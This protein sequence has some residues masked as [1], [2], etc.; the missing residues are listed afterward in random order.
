[1]IN[2]LKETFRYR[3]VIFNFVYTNLK[4]R[5][6]RSVL[7]YLWTVLAP[8][9]YYF[10][11][12]FIFA[13][14]LKISM[15]GSN[16]YVYMFSGAVIFSVISTV[17]IQSCGIMLQNEGYIKK[18][19]IPKLVFI[20][21]VVFFEMTNF[22]LVLVALLILGFSSSQI[23]FSVHYYFV[24]IPILLSIFFVSGVA[25][26]LSIASVYFRDLIH[27]IPVLMNA[28]FFITPIMYFKEYSP[29]IITKLNY[30]NPFFYFVEL[31]RVPFLHN[32][33]PD[34]WLLG[35]CACFTLLIFLFGLFLLD[36]F[37]NRIIFK[38]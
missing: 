18:I 24:L 7:G 23:I 3:Y 31:F 36:K 26:I 14:G 20:F 2:E 37:N 21:N 30:F 12:A 29:P 33:L 35:V 34:M 4:V 22:L 17:V 38:L 32:Q 25:I 6:K 13:N 9:A 1:M 28:L 10:V 27:I 8:M 16:Y 11:L 15:P 5:Y 19:Y